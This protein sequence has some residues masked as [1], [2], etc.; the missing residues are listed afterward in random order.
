MRFSLDVLLGKQFNVGTPRL[1]VRSQR[2]RSTSSLVYGYF[3]KSATESS[4]VPTEEQKRALFTTT[5]DLNARGETKNSKLPFLLVSSDI[6]RQILLEHNTSANYEHDVA[7]AGL[8]GRGKQLARSFRYAWVRVSAMCRYQGRAETTAKRLSRGFAFTTTLHS[9]LHTPLPA[10]AMAAVTHPQPT[11]ASRHHSPC[12]GAV[13]DERLDCSPPTKDEPGS[14]PGRD[15]PDFRKWESCLT[16]TLVGG[17]SRESPIFP[18]FAFWLCSILS[19]F[20]HHRLSRPFTQQRRNARPGETGDPL[21][22]PPT[23]GIVRHDSLIRNPG[24]TSPAIEPGLPWWEASSLTTTPPRSPILSQYTLDLR[25][26][27]GS[28]ALTSCGAVGLCFAPVGGTGGSGFESCRQ[29]VGVSCQVA[30]D[31]VDQSHRLRTTN[32]RVT[33]LN[34]FSVNTTS[35]NRRGLDLSVVIRHRASC[36][37]KAG[38][39][40]ESAI[41]CCKEPPQHSPGVISGNQ[42]KQGSGWPDRDSN[43]DPP[44]ASRKIYRCATSLHGT[45]TS[46]VLSQAACLMAKP[47]SPASDTS[48]IEGKARKPQFKDD[49]GTEPRTLRI[50]ELQDALLPDIIFGNSTTLLTFPWG[51]GGVV[52]RLLAYR[53]LYYAV[54]FFPG[55][56]VVSWLDYSPPG[57]STKLLTFSLGPRWCR[58]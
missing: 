4:K 38:T 53:E 25:V 55:A 51:R 18:T 14:I 7:W 49:A 35:K 5:R 11:L 46:S 44:N 47:V 37:E 13:G 22:N 28:F 8:R 50:A 30:K 17:F 27:D 52:V 3:S 23:T 31:E 45:C 32:L 19:S 42:R 58:G 40:M 20:H 10:C 43:P 2:E 16:T 29:G 21:E 6:P 34:C 24:V 9:H 54:D 1:V 36:P 33:I 56:A 41:A 57:N 48:G 12:K 26:K 39:G 15:T